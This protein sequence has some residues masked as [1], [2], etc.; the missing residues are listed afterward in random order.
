M[1]SFWSNE[2][3][4]L[5]FAV[6]ASLS[7]PVAEATTAAAHGAAPTA[8]RS[9]VAEKLPPIGKRKYVLDGKDRAA[10]VTIESDQETPSKTYLKDP[11]STAPVNE[12]PA[13]KTAER[14]APRLPAARSAQLRFKH[15]PVSGKLT[16][17]RVEFKNDVIPVGRADEPVRQDFFPKVFDPALDYEF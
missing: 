4:G 7:A 10:P 17:P 12:K 15:L 16:R 6:L 9:D 2:L 11:V 14:R 8:L 1:R 3:A 5:G 13:P